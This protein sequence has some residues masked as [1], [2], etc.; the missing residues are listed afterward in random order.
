MERRV[1][2]AGAVDVVEEVVVG[3]HEGIIA[4]LR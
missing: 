3:A 1:R 2:G 4:D